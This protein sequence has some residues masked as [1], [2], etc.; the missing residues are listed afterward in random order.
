M[1]AIIFYPALAALAAY[2]F[3]KYRTTG[4]REHLKS[5]G[6][7]VL[8]AVFFA[9][10]GRAIEGVVYPERTWIAYTV[11]LA[12]ALAGTLLLAAGYEG[13]RKASALAQGAAFVVVTSLFVS[14]MPYFRMPVIVSRAH[15]DC[16]LAVPGSEL[17]V[18]NGL[19]AA[20]KED[21]AARLSPALGS[22]EHFVRLGALYKLAYMPEASL[23]A[24]PAVIKLLGSS[25][26]TDELE[27][28]AG[29]LEK[30][31]PPAA[32]AVPALESRLAGAD[33][34]TSAGLEAALKALRPAK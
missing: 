27:A 26:D 8:V 22:G 32:A 25:Q 33:G 18:L 16:S 29:L 9:S 4:D 10:M 24:L 2:Y 12:G 28:A 15:R 19:S 31:G 5:C 3:R 21:L 7:T 23:T 11:L 6:T 20:R 34:R 30:M 14:S 1:I 13:W 17:K